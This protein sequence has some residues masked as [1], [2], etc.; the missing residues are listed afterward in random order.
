[1]QFSPVLIWYIIHF[2]YEISMFLFDG[3]IQSFDDVSPQSCN[4]KIIISS[5]VSSHG[6][7]TEAYLSL[8]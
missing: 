7:S 2:S 5:E 6:E 3:E 8:R 4:R 1:M